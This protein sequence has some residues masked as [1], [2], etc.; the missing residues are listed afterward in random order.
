MTLQWGGGGGQEDDDGAECLHSTAVVDVRSALLSLRASLRALP[1]TADAARVGRAAGAHAALERGRAAASDEDPGGASGAS[2]SGSGGGSRRLLPFLM[3][4]GALKKFGSDERSEGERLAALPPATALAVRLF[5]KLLGGLGTPERGA[6]LSRIVH[7]LPT[8]LLDFPP[9]AFADAP[10]S[11]A[12]VAGPDG[13]LARAA[14]AAA[15]GGSGAPLAPVGV[16]RGL[17]RAFTDA[18]LALPDEARAHGDVA[19]PP[20]AAAAAAA[21]A[22]GP[23]PQRLGLWS[24]SPP[25]APPQRTAAAADLIAALTAVAVKTG[26]LEQL[27]SAVRLLLFGRAALVVA[28]DGGAGAAAVTV[29]RP[30]D[31]DGTVRV[32]AALAELSRAV[33]VRC[34]DEM[35]GWHG[36]PIGHVFTCGPRGPG[37]AAGAPLPFARAQQQGLDDKVCGHAIYASKCCSP[38]RRGP[39]VLTGIH[40]LPARAQD[41][42]KVV[43]CGAVTLALTVA[44]GVVCWGSGAALS[45]GRVRVPVRR[46][47]RRPCA[48]NSAAPL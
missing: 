47:R 27:L 12:Y 34:A 40:S 45:F 22:A 1:P 25:A 29:A 23:P 15:A 28:G 43:M 20:A 18:L 38:R 21:A 41:V 35:E 32:G 17:A 11:T 6:T 33:V 14:A 26:S 24:V 30:V 8:I 7:R 4:A 16:V 9:L 5:F 36:E 46:R 10:T 3:S 19:A 2:G 39:R 37:D 48:H 13:A 44:G 42:V 31:C